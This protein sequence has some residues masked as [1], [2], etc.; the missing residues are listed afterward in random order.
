MSRSVVYEV[1]SGKDVFDFVV[2]KDTNKIIEAIPSNIE[3]HYRGR[4]YHD[5]V[6]S[7][8]K[9]NPYVT[10]RFVAVFS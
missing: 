2:A 6:K 4:R 7:M 5:V 9:A 10:T 1:R 8:K 3:V